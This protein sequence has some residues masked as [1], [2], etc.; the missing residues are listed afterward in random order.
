MIDYL[1]ANPAAQQTIEHGVLFA[2]LVLVS[3]IAFISLK[4]E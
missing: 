2:S 4:G 1:I 3:T